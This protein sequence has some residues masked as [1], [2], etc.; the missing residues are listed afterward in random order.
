M[1]LD[2]VTASKRIHDCCIDRLD[3]AVVYL[4]R[5]WTGRKGYILNQSAAIAVIFL[6]VGRDTGQ[7]AFSTNTVPALSV[8][9]SPFICGLRRIEE[10]RAR[11]SCEL[12]NGLLPSNSLGGTITLELLECALGLLEI[13]GAFLEFRA[14]D[15][16]A[17][18]EAGVLNCRGGWN[19][20]RFGQP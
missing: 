20:D 4:P 2:I 5:S 8:G 13:Q 16:R 14:V 7:P 6:L 11:R 17:F 9:T 15:F 18:I 10:G 1:G 3:V 19:R 12:G